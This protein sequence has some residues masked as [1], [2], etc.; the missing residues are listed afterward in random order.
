MK[1]AN[2]EIVLA[3]EGYTAK[4]SCKNGIESVAANAPKAELAQND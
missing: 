1:A 4:A 3:S 2:G